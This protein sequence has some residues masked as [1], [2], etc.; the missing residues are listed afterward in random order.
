MKTAT[1]F[2]VGVMVTSLALAVTGGWAWGQETKKAPPKTDG[3]LP[4]GCIQ[5]QHV[6]IGFKGS[7]PN[8]PIERT[9]EASAK[10]AQQVFGLAKKGENFDNLVATFTADSVPGVYLLCDLPKKPGP[11][12]WLRSGM[13]KSFG[14]VAFS[15]K[16]GEVGMTQFD[17]HFSPYGWHIIKRLK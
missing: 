1:R 11:E 5:V 15:L 2:L 16:V 4:A 6:L 9:K 10:V 12:F 14:D 13:V 7:V 17:P 3:A 8:K